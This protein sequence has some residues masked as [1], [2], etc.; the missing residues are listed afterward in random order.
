MERDPDGPMIDARGIG[1]RVWAEW[2]VEATAVDFEIDAALV[3]GVSFG[4]GARAEAV[5]D[6]GKA[7]ERTTQRRMTDYWEA[8]RRAGEL[9]PTR[10]RVKKK[11]GGRRRGVVEESSDRQVARANALFATSRAPL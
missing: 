2:L 8:I 6:G 4:E 5:C 7:G 9:F 10:Q 11:K 1:D 3:D